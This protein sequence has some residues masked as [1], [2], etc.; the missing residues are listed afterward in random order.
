MKDGNDP[1]GMLSDVR[2]ACGAKLPKSV[3]VIIV[4]HNTKYDGELKP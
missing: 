4:M 1:A 3:H 2:S